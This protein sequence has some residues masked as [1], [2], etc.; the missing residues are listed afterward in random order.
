MLAGVPVATMVAEV[1]AMLVESQVEVAER[2]EK[3][4]DLIRYP[5]DEISSY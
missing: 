2:R 1:A 4:N 5:Y 3:S